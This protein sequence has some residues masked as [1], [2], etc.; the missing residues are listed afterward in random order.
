VVA[1]GLM[2]CRDAAVLGRASRA[3]QGDAIEAE[4]GLGQRQAAVGFRAIRFPTLRTVGVEAATHL[5]GES[6]NSLQGVKGR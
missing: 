3:P 2:D 6:S 1:Q 5:E 4:G